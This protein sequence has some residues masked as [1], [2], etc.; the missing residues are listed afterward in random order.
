MT[1]T[2]GIATP[3][4]APPTGG[5][6]QP[7]SLAGTRLSGAA[8]MAVPCPLKTPSQDF[9][10]SLQSILDAAGISADDIETSADTKNAQ[11]SPDAELRGT[12]EK[13]PTQMGTPAPQAFR[14][15]PRPVARTLL[16]SAGAMHAGRHEE[17]SSHA[18]SSPAVSRPGLSEAKAA[19]TQPGKETRAERTRREKKGELSLE[20]S[21]Q[22]PVAQPPIPVHPAVSAPAQPLNPPMLTHRHTFPES[23]GRGLGAAGL[24]SATRHGTRIVDT[25][26][27]TGK[28]VRIANCAGD[29]THSEGKAGT[30]IAHDPVPETGSPSSAVLQNEASKDAAGQPVPYSAQ[31]NGATQTVTHHLFQ[32]SGNMLSPEARIHASTVQAAPG[33]LRMNPQGET[34]ASDPPAS[35]GESLAASGKAVAAESIAEREHASPVRS[36]SVAAATHSIAAVPMQSA[37]TAVH[38]PSALND[39]AAA[40]ASISPTASPPASGGEAPPTSSTFSALDAAGNAGP[41]T[42]IHASAHRA[43]VGFQDPAL[44]W[45]GVRAQTDVHGI[46]AALVPGSADA[47]QALGT[48]LA[49][50]HAYLADHHTPVATLTLT[51]QENHWV[52]QGMGQGAG[53]NAGQ[54]P[55]QGGHSGQPDVHDGAIAVASAN[56]S[57]TAVTAGGPSV[58][59]APGGIYIS[60]MA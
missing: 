23:P 21:A 42:W 43:E 12:P 2:A 14:P 45:V 10:A 15:H 50:L 56:G 11:A 53:Q 31:A 24:I 60:V 35:S 41:A 7:G 58:E 16:P 39:G 4:T 20:K 36:K 5:R 37:A 51:A 22:T 55:G 33:A 48:H 6:E 29:E 59:M 54:N 19:A 27:T 49:G 57:H 38:E 32:A 34:R 52:E 8:W 25:D 28:T 9:G 30:V 1:A 13:A 46:H 3:S 47:A 26:A 18:S 40:K 17:V 44:G